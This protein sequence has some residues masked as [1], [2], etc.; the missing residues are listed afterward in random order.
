MLQLQLQAWKHRLQGDI[1]ING[2]EIFNTAIASDTFAGKLNL[3]NSFTAQ[4]GVTASARFDQTFAVDP[5]NIIKGDVIKLNGTRIE[6]T[7][8]ND[9]DA[10]VTALNGRTDATGLVA[11]RSGNNITFTGENVQSLTIE[12][13]TKAEVTANLVSVVNDKGASAL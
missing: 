1:T 8:S 5:N 13:D 12:Q 11:S 10:L 9:V 4:T 2:V 6:V 7:A 3:I